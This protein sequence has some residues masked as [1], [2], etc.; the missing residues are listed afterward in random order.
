[1]LTKK[2]LMLMP[3]S[4]PYAVS[5]LAGEFYYRVFS[6]PTHQDGHSL[7]NRKL[8]LIRADK[9]FLNDT[10]SIKSNPAPV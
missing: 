10:P 9:L 2:K 4:S 6:G 1:M 3:L 8:P 7:Y 5:K